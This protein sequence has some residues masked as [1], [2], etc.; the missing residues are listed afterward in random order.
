M[1][2]LDSGGYQ[3]PDIVDLGSFAELTQSTTGSSQDHS[4]GQGSQ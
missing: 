3:A 1:N 2:D 4:S